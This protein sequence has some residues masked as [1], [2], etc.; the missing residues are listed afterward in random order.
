[1]RHVVAV[2]LVALA[3]TALGAGEEEDV[4][5]LKDGRTIR[6]SIVEHIPGEWLK[7]QTK[8]GVLVC[9][10]DQI[11]QVTREPVMHVEPAVWIWSGDRVRVSSQGREMT[12]AVV[13]ADED[14]FDLDPWRGE[15][16]A[17]LYRD[18]QRLERSLGRKSHWKTGFVAGLIPGGLIVAMGNAAA[19]EGNRDAAGALLVG[20]LLIGG[21][22]GLLGMV[23][24]ALIATE[25]W[26]LI[27]I[28]ETA[29]GFHDGERPVLKWRN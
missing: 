11:G 23:V 15:P 12:G 18:V 10:I 21:A 24:G 27:P 26:E 28:R 25:E 22:G 16:I 7:I 20:G 1:M 29:P 13:M 6:G 4:L 2:Y 3:A 19:E 8:G 9:P 5:H 17:V 14:G